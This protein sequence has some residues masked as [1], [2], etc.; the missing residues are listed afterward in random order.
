MSSIN[1][2]SNIA[3]GDDRPLKRQRQDG[4]QSDDD[5]S[6]QASSSA[7]PSDSD[8]SEQDPFG[9][10]PSGPDTPWKHLSEQDKSEELK[11]LV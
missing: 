6:E 7:D 10:P 4:D 9:Q 2:V 5:A 11:W 1:A 8:T 3:P